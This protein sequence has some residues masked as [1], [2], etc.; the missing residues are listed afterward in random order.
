MLDKVLFDL[1]GI[2]IDISMQQFVEVYD[3]VNDSLHII[4]RAVCTHLLR[5]LFTVELK[6]IEEFVVEVEHDT[7]YRIV[8]SGI[9]LILGNIDG[10]HFT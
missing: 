2:I 1:F 7:S 9:R 4:C 3:D 8:C 10:L 6:L 5:R